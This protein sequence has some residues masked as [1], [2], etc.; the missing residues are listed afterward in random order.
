VWA[1]ARPLRHGPGE[2]IAVHLVAHAGKDANRRDPIGHAVVDLHQHRPSIALQAFD[3][4]AFPQRAVAVQSA[5]QHV[6]DNPEQFGVI[7]W[8]RYCHPPHMAADVESRIVDPLRRTNVERQG[9]Q[10]LRASRNRS[11]ALCQN[12]FEFLVLGHRAI[13]DGDS[14]DRQTD[15]A[16]RI[17]GHEEARI[18]RI[19]LLHEL[20]PPFIL[21]IA[22]EY[23]R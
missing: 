7:T 8:A 9:A 13:D 15:V 4:P 14:A 23:R 19:E 10:H 16:V 5:L 3:D 2:H 1:P 20:S 12:S 22:C 11:N 18:E 21:W 6:G 17:L